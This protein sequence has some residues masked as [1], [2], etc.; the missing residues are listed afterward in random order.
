[1]SSNV[2]SLTAKGSNSISK[3]DS[4]AKIVVPYNMLNETSSNETTV[5]VQIDPQDASALDFEGVTGAIGRF[6]AG[7]SCVTFDLKGYQYEGRIH[8]G[9]TAM[10]VSYSNSK[11]G[12]DSTATLR[13]DS[14]TNEFVTLEKTTDSLAQL[15]AK[16]TGDMQGYEVVEEDANRRS[17][18]QQDGAN[19]NGS[20]AGKEDQEKQENK[21]PTKKRKLKQSKSK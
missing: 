20:S 12:E 6:E 4:V 15:D 9:P 7:S 16:V 21:R 19:N 17:N 18:K 14:I 11:G 13:V 10:V 8:P 5:L 3:T 2:V 1:M